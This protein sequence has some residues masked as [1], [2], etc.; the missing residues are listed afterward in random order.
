[1]ERE[2]RGGRGGGE[3]EKRIEWRKKTNLT[4]RPIPREDPL[5][6]LLLSY[7]SVRCVMSLTY[8]T[9]SF[10]DTKKRRERE[11]ETINGEEEEGKRE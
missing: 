10:H 9:I 4:T 1:M 6:T 2:G 7:V 3:G 11:K 8:S 5:S